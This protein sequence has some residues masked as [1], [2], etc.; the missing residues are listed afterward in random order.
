MK[1]TLRNSPVAILCFSLACAAALA[2]VQPSPSGP[3]HSRFGHLM[4]RMNDRPTLAVQSPG[5][6]EP[7]LTFGMV[8]FPGQMDT[9]GSAANDKGEIVGGYGPDVVGDTVSN[10]GFS[11]KGTKFTE[12]DYPGA[13]WTEPN[14]IN[15]SGAI[16]GQYG[17][18]FTGPE[19][20]FELVGKTYTTIVYPGAVDT[21]AIGINKSGDIVGY[22]D[23]GGDGHGF[24]LSKGIFTS[25]DVPGATTTSALGIN[26]AGEIVGLYYNSDA[27]SH[28]FLLQSG[29]FTT[30]DYP[31][32]YSQNYL[33]GINDQGEMVGAYGELTTI[34]GV[35][36]AWEHAF[37]HQNGQFTN[38]DAPFGPPAA[39]Q[40]FGI[41][42]NGVIVGEYVDNSGTVYGYEATVAQ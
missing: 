40:P 17:A 19:R 4:S 30:I 27:S 5:S 31:G 28:G 22:W 34:N 32:G 13:G 11:L 36:Y 8:D 21:S 39:T 16:V 3:V 15:D 23:S 42:N 14:A 25:I 18:S 41:S 29:T 10:H 20:G 12:I 2:Q 38:A 6:P 26:K 24:L 35:S 37:I 33:W 1:L 7:T 9:A